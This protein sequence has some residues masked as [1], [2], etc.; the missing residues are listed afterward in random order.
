MNKKIV[1]DSDNLVDQI[2][3]V[4]RVF[5]DKEY[6]FSGKSNPA[7]LSS[8]EISRC[9]RLLVQQKLC[10]KTI[11]L[12]EKTRMAMDSFVK[13]IWIN[14]LSE[15]ENF[16]VTDRDACFS[17]ASINFSCL[18]DAIIRIGKEPFVFLFRYLGKKEFEDA[19]KNGI[20]RKD[21]IDM[22]GCLLLSQL[23]DGIL[24]YQHNGSLAYHIKWSKEVSDAVASRCR[25]INNFLI[26]KEIPKKC[27]GF[28]KKRCYEKC[29]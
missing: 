4:A 26:N 25:K 18:V 23:H 28:E 2:K 16:V 3:F 12:K 5:D 27:T 11:S 6:L 22:A 21:V 10:G 15:S 24:I 14:L 29:V 7:L 8:R 13:N 17:D 9:L 19:E 1:F 20:K